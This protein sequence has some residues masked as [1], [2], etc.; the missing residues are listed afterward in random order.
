MIRALALSLATAGPALA[1]NCPLEQGLALSALQGTAFDLIEP[2]TLGEDNGT[3]RL[4]GVVLSDG[5]TLRY[6]VP[7]VEWRIE[8]LD[9]FMAGT[10]EPL[11]ISLDI[12]RAR[13]TPTTPDPWINYALAVQN[14][15]NFMDLALRADWDPDLSRLRVDEARIDLPGANGVVVSY[16]VTGV[17]AEMLLGTI[18][19]LEDLRLTHFDL[20]VENEGF[21]DSV[22]LFALMDRLRGFGDTPETAVET[23]SQTAR[24]RIAGLPE[25][26]F[27]APTRDALDRMAQGLPMPRGRMTLT[28]KG[29]A[30]PFS[31]LFEQGL[32]PD[33]LTPEI[34]GEVFRGI[35]LDITY[36]PASPPD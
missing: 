20:R 1:T 33:P 11:S 28:K 17:G 22:V 26:S 34:L 8:G 16:E 25:A 24:G 13:F 30:L 14:R 29:E 27:P 4:E 5:E 36:A 9:A 15:W 23:L 21:F 19:G 3:C 6:D 12:R 10:P 2:G 7:L 35:E 31:R 18:D 32:A